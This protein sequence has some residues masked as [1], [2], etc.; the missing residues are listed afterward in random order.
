MALGITVA[1]KTNFNHSAVSD[2]VLNNEAILENPKNSFEF[3][4]NSIEVELSKFDKEE[5]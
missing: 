2:Q 1:F 4:L 5:L 3:E